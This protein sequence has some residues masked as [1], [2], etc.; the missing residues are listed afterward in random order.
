MMRR[1]RG[2]C[3][4]M[5]AMVAP[6]A[7]FGK[8]RKADPSGVFWPLIWAGGDPAP[9]IGSS[10]TRILAAT[11]M[12]NIARITRP[13]RGLIVIVLALRTRHCKLEHTA[14]DTGT[15]PFYLE[16]GAQRT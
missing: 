1:I 3:D 11:E 10:V 4:L 13:A 9:L 2:R 14:A 6:A 5:P 8:T 15:T 7:A 16:I 12:T